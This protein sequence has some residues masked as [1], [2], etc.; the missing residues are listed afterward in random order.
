M[1][2]TNG[3]QYL[4]TTVSTCRDCGQLIPA[5]V[6]IMDGAIWFQ[7]HCAE[8]GAQSAR[9]YG[10]ADEYLGLDRYHRAGAV[11]LEFDAS[12]DES[13]PASCGLCP[14]H[15]QH[16]CLPIL[17]ITDHCDLE[18][19][20]CL[21]S[22]R[23]S[24]HLSREQVARML[25]RLIAS[26]AQIDVL[27]LSGGEPTVNP[28][29][30][31]I[32][33]ECLSRKEVLRVTVSTNGLNLLRLPDLLEFLAERGV[34]ISLQ[35][36]SFSDETYRAL[37]G[38]PLLS[39]K[40]ELIERIS[41][42][43]AAMSLTATVAR[44]VNDDRLGEL[45]TLL[46][47]R[48]NILSLMLQPAAYTGNAG[49]SQRPTDIVTIPDLTR[50]LDGA[51]SGRVAMGD[52]TP[53][54][55]SHPACFCLAFYLRLDSGAFVSIKQLTEIDRYLDIIQNRS[56]FG[57][58]SESFDSIRAAVYDLWSGPSG[59]APDSE[60][61]L[62]AVRRLLESVTTAPSGFDPARAVRLAERS[63][64]S[65]FIHHFMD[66]DTFDLARARKCCNVYPLADGRM[67]PCCVYNCLRR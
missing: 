61:A 49:K 12:M 13:C 26:E 31:E 3:S 1:S 25:D 27:N 34:V 48:D 18:C 56:L 65:I 47:E 63:I 53:L 60:R 22:N 17:E 6:H 54:P 35:F 32:V 64:K 19:P 24:F 55:C 10:D 30:R 38:R 14:E 23:S 57:T 29:F 39:Q 42:L 45:V 4:T 28:H 67:I 16:I 51:D 66:R 46:F 50:R 36:D 2:E 9:V 44:G 33:D 37:R 8:H 40:L 59:T 58:D 52:F 11:P 15:E 21:V 20:I 43:D 62:K 41:E 7:K 5:R